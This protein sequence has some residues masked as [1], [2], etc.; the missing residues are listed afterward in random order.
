MVDKRERET[1][2]QSHWTQY[3]PKIQPI[4]LLAAARPHPHPEVSNTFQ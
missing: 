1:A 3:A 4:D 2:E